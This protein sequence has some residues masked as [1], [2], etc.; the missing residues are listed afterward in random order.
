M[1]STNFDSGSV[2]RSRKPI[3]CMLKTVEKMLAVPNR[4]Q[5]VNC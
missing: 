1:F 5:K 4:L 2:S 3:E